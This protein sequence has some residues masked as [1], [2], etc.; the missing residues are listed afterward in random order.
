MAK[1]YGNWVSGNSDVV[2]TALEQ[3]GA[4][5]TNEQFRQKGPLGLWPIV[6]SP[7]QVATPL[8][9]IVFALSSG[10]LDEALNTGDYLVPSGQA[11]ST[12]TY[13]EL[14]SD[15]GY[16]FGGSGS[17]FNLP[18][19]STEFLYLKPTVASGVV[20]SGQF[21]GKIPDHSHSYTRRAGAVGGNGFAGGPCF[22][23]TGE[24]NTSLG[25]SSPAHSQNRA[26][27]FLLI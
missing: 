15:Y 23:S 9:S 2:P 25:N 19:L 11:V 1:H 4:W 8:G 10:A 20:P 7:S 22:R 16:T 12:V 13:S 5:N 18:N 17:S 26:P 21:K 6:T 14:F 24:G 3:Y 27:S